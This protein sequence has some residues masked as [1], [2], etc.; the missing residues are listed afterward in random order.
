MPEQR[1]MLEIVKRLHTDTELEM[2]RDDLERILDEELSKPEN[3]LDTELIQEIVLLL[4]DGATIQE[5]EAAWRDTAVKLQE[6]PQKKRKPSVAAWAARIAA[7][8]VV[9]LGLM[10]LTYKTAEAFNWQM[11]LRLMRPFAET[12]M[13]YSGEQPVPTAAPVEAYGDSGKAA[14]S[15]DYTSLDE[16]PDMLLGYPVKP[17]GIP[18]RFAYLQSS[19]YSDDLNTS[20]THMY[21]DDQGVCIFTVMILHDDG[22]MS[23]Q[24]YERTVE[25]AAERYIAGCRVTF[26]FNSDDATMSASWVKENA[27]YSLFGMISE[28][29]LMTIVESTMNR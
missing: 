24:A 10:V 15:R 14:E 19:V 8:L 6:Q 1:E 28:E 12:F 18:E 7:V 17:Y 13:L 4:E 25:D 26:Y 9:A 23:G 5:Q 3:Q 20:V 29:E 27:Q 22:L 2:T 21:A 16:A 11:L